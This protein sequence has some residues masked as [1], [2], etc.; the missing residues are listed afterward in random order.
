M[1]HHIARHRARRIAAL[2]AMLAALCVML[3]I[4]APSA[5]ASPY[6]GGTR[7]SN[8]ARCVGASR[9]LRGT[10]GHGD[11][12]SVCVGAGAIFGKCSGGP[13]QIATWEFGSVINAEP[14]IQDNASGS[15]IVWGETF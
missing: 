10:T 15:T 4:A 8:F 1:S 6:C 12:H 5:S 3:A 14:W 2:V 9:S 13:G 7:L 11:E